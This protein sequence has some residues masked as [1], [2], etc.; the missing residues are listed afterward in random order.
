MRRRNVLLVVSALGILG[1]AVWGVTTASLQEPSH[2]EQTPTIPNPLDVGGDRL[3]SWVWAYS[4]PGPKTCYYDASVRF[5][6]GKVGEI[7]KVGERAKDRIHTGDPISDLPAGMEEGT[8]IP[9]PVHIG[10]D[11]KIRPGYDYCEEMP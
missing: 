2:S 7:K 8:T 4:D 9:I 10:D 5:D 11:G 1:L 6:H 3:V